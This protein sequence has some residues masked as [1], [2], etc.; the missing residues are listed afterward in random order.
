Q[1]V[2]V[3][4]AQGN[5][6]VLQ[7]YEV[8]LDEVAKSAQVVAAGGMAVDA[9]LPQLTAISLGNAPKLDVSA[10]G[11]RLDLAP[12]PSP[13]ATGEL[14]AQ[15]LTLPTRAAPLQAARLSS[16]KAGRLVT[17]YG[18]EARGGRAGAGES[19]LL[20]M[21]LTKGSQQ[22]QFPLPGPSD[23]LGVDNEGTVAAT[24]LQASEG[25]IDL[26]SLTDGSPV[27]AWRPYGE[28]K[29]DHE[30]KVLAAVVIDKDHVLTLSQANRLVMWDLPGKRAVYQI[31]RAE[32][33]GVSPGRRWLTVWNG[34][35]VRVFDALTGQV[36]GDLQLPADGW[37]PPSSAAF[38]PNGEHLAVC[39]NTFPSGRV[40]V[41]SLKTGQVEHDFVQPV[42]SQTLH[43]CDDGHLLL[44]NTA[45]VD[46]K[47][48]V[49]VWNYELPFGKG[50]HVPDSPDGRHWYLTSSGGQQATVTLVAAKLPDT[51]TEQKLAGRKLA[52]EYLLQ[53]G[54]KVGVR[55]NFTST[56]PKKPN[57]QE[58]VWKGLQQALSRAGMVYEEKSSLI[59]VLHLASKATGENHEFRI[60]SFGRGGGPRQAT[61]PGQEVEV[62][63]EVWNGNQKIYD[64]KQKYGNG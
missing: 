27:A 63:V 38:H 48:R 32:M 17:L 42:I 18:P 44:D 64:S 33:P 50:V 45:L 56:P 54:S 43:W 16:A 34:Q 3:A 24:R 10:G 59:F 52:P 25:R 12:D 4:G 5:A 39:L 28:E 26:F 29:H 57:F 40:V 19:E 23:L 20:V 14:L 60:T 31:E 36:K 1:T 13:S 55:F 51:G 49:L 58:E 8:P 15:P 41:W 9:K 30:Q 37:G 21:D 11:A 7:P 35:G 22:S 61:V 62:G 47:N 53:P 46:L 2:L 6:V